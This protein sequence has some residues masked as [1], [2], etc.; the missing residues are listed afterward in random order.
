MRYCVIVTGSGQVVWNT[1]GLFLPVELLRSDRAADDLAFPGERT[2]RLPRSLCRR[3]KHEE[4]ATVLQ[5]LNAG[6]LTSAEYLAKF[7]TRGA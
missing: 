3:G 5:R 4:D 1:A 2:I 7:C 6:A